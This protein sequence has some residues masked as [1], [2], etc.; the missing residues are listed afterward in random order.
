MRTGFENNVIKDETISKIIKEKG[1]EIKCQDGTF[2]S[3]KGGEGENDLVVIAQVSGSFFS[4]LTNQFHQLISSRLLKV[5]K[6][7]RLA[8]PAWPSLFPFSESQPDVV[9]SFRPFSLCLLFWSFSKCLVIISLSFQAWHW[10]PN[11]NLAL[12]SI[13]KS[14]KPGGILALI[15]NLEDRETAPWVGKLR[16]FYEVH[17]DNTPQCELCSQLPLPS[18]PTPLFFWPLLLVPSQIVTTTG[19]QCTQL[20]QCPT[21]LL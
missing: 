10:C 6:P 3:F 18:D 4:F 16:D 12:S 11:F 19:I 8:F 7:R 14:L 20:T 21:L 13:S 17:E 9:D 1:I 15:W 5:A 2:E